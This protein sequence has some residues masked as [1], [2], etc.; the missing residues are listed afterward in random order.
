MYDTI[1]VSIRCT[2]EECEQ[3]RDDG[4]FFEA[5]AGALGID[6]DD[7]TEVSQ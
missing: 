5:I 3:L 6:R 2:S 7:V 4:Q 1:I